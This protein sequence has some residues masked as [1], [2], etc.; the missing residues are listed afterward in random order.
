LLAQRKATKRK[1]TPD[2]ALILRFSGKSA[3]A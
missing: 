1:G 3:L 2:G